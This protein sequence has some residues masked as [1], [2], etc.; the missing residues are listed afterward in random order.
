MGGDAVP[1]NID[2]KPS[3]WAALPPQR[4]NCGDPSDFSEHTLR[5]NLLLRSGGPR[6]AGVTHQRAN[7]VW[8]NL[9]ITREPDQRVATIGGSHHR[10]Q[11]RYQC[12]TLR[13]PR[14]TG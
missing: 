4:A 2:Q 14:G 10:K 11:A 12:V 1:P 8:Y 6:V 5:N 3:M 9:D 13:D 7:T